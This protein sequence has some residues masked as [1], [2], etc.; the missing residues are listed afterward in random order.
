M[1]KTLRTA[2]M[3]V[4]AVALTATGVGAIAAAA[5]GPGF[6]A[7]SVAGVSMS[8]WTALA[9]GSG[10]VTMATGLAAPG[11]SLQGS[12]TKFAAD[13]QAGIPYAI[14]RTWQS[15]NIIYRKA[16]TSPGKVPNDRQTFVAVLSGGG[17]VQQID[18]FY[19]DKTQVTFN[20]AGAA[21]GNYANYM[22]QKTQL[23]A[24]PE[25]AALSVSSG[26][27]SSPPGWTAQ[28]KLS[29]YAAAIWTLRW[30]SKG[31]IYPNGVPKPGWVGK[32]VKVY[33]PRLD[34]T[35]PGGSGSCRALQESTYVWSENPYLHALT[36]CLGRWAN[37]KRV[38]G[39][40]A[41]VEGIDVAAFV[42]GANIADAN[43]WKAGGVEYST[44]RK[45]DVLKRILQAG[46]GEPMPLGARISCRINT[47]RVSLGTVTAADVVGEATVAATQSRR[48]RFNAVIPRYRSEAH[49]WE[50]VAADKIVV[51]EHVAEDGGERCKEITYALVQQAKQAAE[52]ARYDIENSREFGPIT[53]PLKPR[54]IGYKPGDCVTVDLPELGLSSQLVLILRR[55]LDPSTG[56]VTLICRSE[57][58]AKHAFALGQ[59]TTPPPTP[60]VSGPPLVPVPSASEWSVSATAISADGVSR[61][62]L[63]IS[64]A[65]T[66]ADP[67]SILFEYREATGSWGADEGWIAAGTA[68]GSA[69]RQVIPGVLPG[70]AY[71]V[72]VS[73]VQFGQQGGRLKLGPVTTGG[74]TALDRAT[75]ALSAAQAAEAIAADAQAVADGK[76]DLFYQPSAPATP[77]AAVGD[78]WFDTDDGSRQ[79]VHVGLGLFI[80]GSEVTI[81]G[82]SIDIP[83]AL[84]SDQRIGEALTAAAGAQATADGKVRTFFSES[85]PVAEALGDLWYQPSSKIFR[86]WSGSSWDPTSSLGAPAGTEVGGQPAEAVATVAVNF[87]RR[88]DRDGSAIAVPV[89]PTDGTAVDHTINTDGSADISFEWQWSGT[90]ADIDGF[91]IYVYS[92]ASASAYTFGTTPAAEQVFYGPADKRAF[93]LYGA[94]ANKYYTFGVRAY[95]VVDPDVASSGIIQTAIVKPSRAEENPYRPSA[96]V[97]FGGDITG[98]ISGTAA[99][100]IVGKTQNLTDGG[101][102]GPNMGIQIGVLRSLGNGVSVVSLR[103]GDTFTFPAD[104]GA[105]VPG[106]VGMMNGM[107]SGTEFILSEPVGLTSAGF[108]AKCKRVTAV[109]GTPTTIT[110]AAT[111]S[112]PRVFE[113]VKPNADL[114]FNDR[115][116]FKFNVLVTSGPIIAPGERLP[117]SVTL[118]FWTYDGL[119]WQMNSTAWWGSGATEEFRVYTAQTVTVS[120]AGMGNGSRFGI[121]V[122]NSEHG[123]GVTAFTE[124]SYQ[125]VTSVTE[126]TATPPGFPGINFLIIGGAQVA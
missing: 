122:V 34:S 37:G 115:F 3:I 5:A 107:V 8:T 71:E 23:G 84:A 124:V 28:H 77:P 64:G 9:A 106:V 72:A 60:G 75:A 100:V 27:G 16:H 66:T 79:Y 31:K 48:E 102:L 7:V 47:P 53:L 25:A 111:P 26:D 45:W 121:S 94:A 108:T 24:T 40:G 90:N 87:N 123:G 49:G 116:T 95:R 19:A 125:A 78:L 18:A 104:W 114:V 22:W 119:T 118:G 120:R 65:A 17:P 52:L 105:Q 50:I 35:Y 15:G 21:T 101:Q 20:S 82:T 110:A 4:G 73:Y 32:W 63:V 42:E 29:G 126:T 36:W 74:D 41:P 103:D 83:W 12:P 39:I 59:T 81:A 89:I 11:P 6:T 55:T 80:A 43:G 1:G 33:D 57:T 56:I 109:S 62:A 44:D 76:V 14:G 98:T 2:A 92:S 61:P 86:R 85:Q 97:A 58:A 54:W 46:G 38:L 117:G 13:P 112:G 93:I 99:S 68:A 91:V 30:D 96:S 70:T 10:L 113:K 51:P 69:T 88:N 67:H